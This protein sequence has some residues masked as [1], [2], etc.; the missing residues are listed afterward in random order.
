MRIFCMGHN[1]PLRYQTFVYFVLVINTF[2]KTSIYSQF[3]VGVEINDVMLTNT[4]YA[5]VN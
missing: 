2:T 1:W 5:I 4:I 3:V